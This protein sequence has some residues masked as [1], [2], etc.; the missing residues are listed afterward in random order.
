MD[1]WV[2]RY[3]DNMRNIEAIQKIKFI[4]KLEGHQPCFGSGKITCKYKDKCCWASM[5][6]QS[7]YKIHL[8]EVIE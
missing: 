2:D 3:G 4:Q 6:L 1:Y 5:C 7:D 8:I